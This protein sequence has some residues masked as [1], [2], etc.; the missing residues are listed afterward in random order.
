VDLQW[1]Q[2]GKKRVQGVELGVT[3]ALATNWLVSAG[4]LYMDN[5]V[6]QGR[7]ITA[8][9]ENS[10]TYTPKSSFTLWTSYDIT[11]AF[12]VGGGARY[13]DELK[14]GTDGAVGTPKYTEDYWVFDLMASYRVSPNL[15]L[16]LNVY[17]VADEE[18]VS[19][20]NKSGY[21]YTPGAARSATLSA[22]FR[23]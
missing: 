22:N 3:G 10:L 12:K 15:D 1:Y 6:E 19:A 2:T 16:R 17:N 21:R 9:G 5:T 23:F 18:Y 7:A 11:P 8:S 20:I 14:R 13:S 4:Y